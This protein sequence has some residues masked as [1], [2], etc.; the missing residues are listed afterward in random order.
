MHRLATADH[1]HPRPSLTQRRKCKPLILLFVLL[2]AGIGFAQTTIPDTPAGKTLRAWLE[3][4]NSG[5]RA[6]VE[7]YVKTYE[8]DQS[9]DGM[10]SFHDQT[11]GFD[12][13]GR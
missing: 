8:P 7:A 9:P 10:L 13:L 11:G 6:K 5:D 12:L 4:F 3:A 2:W 1:S